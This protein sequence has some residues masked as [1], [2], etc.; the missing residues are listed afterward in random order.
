MFQKRNPTIPVVQYSTTVTGTIAILDA[1]IY[2]LSQVVTVTSFLI[3]ET[4]SN[5]HYSLSDGRTRE[6]VAVRARAVEILLLGRT[7]RCCV[8][9]IR[10]RIFSIAFRGGEGALK[11]ASLSCHELP[12]MDNDWTCRHVWHF[13]GFSNKQQCSRNRH[14]SLYNVSTGRHG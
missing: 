12:T 7:R 3:K 1:Y 4:N 14:V 13:C 8:N 10:H 2:V 11:L 6:E 9:E 5:E